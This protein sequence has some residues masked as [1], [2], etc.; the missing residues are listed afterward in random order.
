MVHFHA[1]HTLSKTSTSHSAQHDTTTTTIRHPFC[2][3][4]DN[5]PPQSKGD[6]PLDCISTLLPPLQP[7]DPP[8]PLVDMKASPNG[9]APQIFHRFA[10]LPP[11]LRTA[12]WELSL[13]HRVHTFP[14]PSNKFDFVNYRWTQE[15]IHGAK[16]E[17]LPAIAHVC[18]EA[19]GVALASG[20]SRKILCRGPTKDSDRAGWVWVDPKR[21]TAVINLGQLFSHFYVN[22]RRSLNMDPFFDLVSRRD[23]HIALDSS[24]HLC[25]SMANKD[26][27]RKV[28]Y[29]LVDGRK[30]CDFVV[31]NL[32]LD[33]TE[34]E[35]A[36]T[37]LFDGLGAGDSV[38]VPI[39]DTLQMSRLFDAQSKFNTVDWLDKWK[40]FTH[41]RKPTNLVEF[42]SR[43][44]KLAAREKRHVQ[45][46]LDFLAGVEV[47]RQG[48][49]AVQI[50]KQIAQARVIRA[51]QPK[52]RPVIMV[53]G[54][55]RN[56]P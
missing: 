45:K 39:E 34:E 12:I 22:C 21:D 10:D 35:A 56:S 23:M 27:A 13:P 33:V 52:L 16:I 26:L 14:R 43:G 47:G 11:E 29:K 2:K 55:A 4:A 46:V 36:S 41:I 25:S 24:W 5:N 44:K 9:A 54:G 53:S 28:Y 19:R 18:F 38:L 48:K 37:G 6:I 20:S 31:F 50:Q 15:H 3:M 8:K 17:Q 42:I 30:E 7:P 51:H 40:N 32:Q 49:D 1:F